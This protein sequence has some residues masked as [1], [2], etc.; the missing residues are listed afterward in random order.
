MLGVEAE[1]ALETPTNCEVVSVSCC[2]IIAVSER[3]YV[4]GKTVE[5]TIT[6]SINNVTVRSAVY[7]NVL[8]L[9][10]LSLVDLTERRVTLS[11]HQIVQWKLN[12]IQT[13]TQAPITRVSTLRPH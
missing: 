4:I 9:L 10:W 5:G 1:Y 7:V 3:A 11:L 8:R 12:I 13:T 6:S 2:T